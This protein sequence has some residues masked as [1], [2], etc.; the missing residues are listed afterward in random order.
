MSLE[1]L[2]GRVPQKMPIKIKDTEE[3]VIETLIS[4]YISQPYNYTVK[5]VFPHDNSQFKHFK[6]TIRPQELIILI[7]GQIE[8]I[9]NELY[10]Y[11]NDIN[12][13][14]THFI[15]KKKKLPDTELPS[16]N[17]IPNPTRYKLLNVH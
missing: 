3:S 14:N 10:V 11:A 7:V 12:F 16:T 13:I 2:F 17:P 5:V 1:S 4:D 15:T 6:T 9:A 8:I